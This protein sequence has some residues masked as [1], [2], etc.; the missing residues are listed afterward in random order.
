MAKDL[1]HDAVRRALEKDGWVITA[2]PYKVKVLGVQYDI[3]WRR[4]DFR[5]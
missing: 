1:F 3:D 2:D 4:K 5:G